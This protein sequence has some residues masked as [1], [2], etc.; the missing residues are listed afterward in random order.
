VTGDP[1]VRKRIGPNPLNRTHYLA[2]VAR[3]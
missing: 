1:P 2:E 3:L